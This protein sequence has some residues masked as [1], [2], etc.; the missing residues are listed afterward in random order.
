MKTVWLSGP[1]ER[2]MG[3]SMGSHTALWEL[4]DVIRRSLSIQL[5]PFSGE[6]LQYV[7]VWFRVRDL[8]CEKTDLLISIPLGLGCYL[9]CLLE[10]VAMQVMGDDES[11]GKRGIL[12]WEAGAEIESWGLAGA[13]CPWTSC[14]SFSRPCFPWLK[15]GVGWVPKIASRVMDAGSQAWVLHDLSYRLC[16]RGFLKDETDHHRGSQWA[17][18]K[19]HH[20]SASYHNLLCY[21]F[22]YKNNH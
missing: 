13:E 18:S 15:Y 9:W 5:F 22:Y 17:P 14:C 6:A 12:E 4:L 21:L 10:L 1:S 11:E 8:A 2:A 19:P 7:L 16:G 3:V 20:L